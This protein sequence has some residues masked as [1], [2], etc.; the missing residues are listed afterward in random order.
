[1]LARRRF[2]ATSLTAVLL[3]AGTATAC[4]S[5]DARGSQVGNTTSSIDDDGNE[6][7][8]LTDN[9]EGH[10]GNPAGVDNR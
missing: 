1:M 10:P 6:G 8:D 9:K 5:D 3:L 7:R 2:L 4:G